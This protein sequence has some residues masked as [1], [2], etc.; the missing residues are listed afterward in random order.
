ME[1][2]EETGCL[3][4]LKVVVV[5]PAYNNV[6]TVASVLK[7]VL[8]YA[9]D[10]MVVN[11]GSTDDILTVLQDFPSVRLITYSRNRG[12][13]Y[14]L[15]KGLEAAAQQGFR[16]ALTMDADGQHFPEDIPV[17]LQEIKACP[18]A[19]VIGARNLAS[20]NMP[21]KNTF[22]NRFS[23]FWFRLETGIRL[24]DTQSGYRL[25]P[26]EKLKGIRFFTRKYEF[27][28][29]VIVRAAWRQ[30]TLR[31]VPVRVYYPPAGERISHFRPFRDFTRISVLN[32]VFVFVAFFW[33][34]PLRFFRKLNREGIRYFIRNYMTGSGESNLRISC[35][36]MLGLFMGIVPVWG[37]Q[38]VVA[39]VLAH[40][41]RLNKVIALVFSNIS[42]PP[43]IPFLLYGSYA[44]GG[45]V[46][47]R[48]L[49]LKLHDVTFAVLKESLW[50]YLAGSVLLA[51]GTGVAGGVIAYLLLTLF[52]KNK[53]RDESYADSAV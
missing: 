42:I 14:A 18:D 24:A 2:K 29:E 53:H 46:L 4:A 41:F 50:Q 51:A 40:F 25:Y 43:M 22:A 3:R 35:A 37:Y 19:L 32:T 30:I 17:F 12:K 49:T 7:R 47:D 44:V 9:G 1:K 38:M 6:A 10:V 33:Y 21:G 20:D 45:W 23:N 36:V 28:L 27:E 11:D 26:L 15:R 48:P 5:I 52:R 13:G 8:E 31:Q 34:W 16:Y 39:V